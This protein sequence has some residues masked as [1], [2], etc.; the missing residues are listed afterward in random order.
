M[1]KG[2]NIRHSLES[3]EDLWNY[4]RYEIQVCLFEDAGFGMKYFSWDFGG[5]N[6]KSSELIGVGR[7]FFYFAAMR[8]GKL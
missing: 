2:K 5:R 7:M 1:V 8:P 6:L 4:R 3:W